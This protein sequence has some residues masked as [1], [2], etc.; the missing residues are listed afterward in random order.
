[1]SIN[2]ILLNSSIDIW[3]ALAGL[4]FFTLGMHFLED[5]LKQLT[6]RKFK[7]FLRKQSSRKI[8]AIGSA[9]VVTAI[10]QSSSVVNLM[11]LAFTGA[12]IIKMKQA[13]GL[14]LGS[15]LG[16]TMSTWF[17][18][19]VGFK[20]DIEQYV[21]PVIAIA[22]FCMML[23][24]KGSTGYNW[25]IFLF[26]LGFLFTGIDF[27]KNG[28]GDIASKFDLTGLNDYPSIVFLLLGIIITALI[29]SS[30]A[31]LAIVLSLLYVNA[32]TLHSGMAVAL[33]AEIGTTLKLLLV[34]TG[35]EPVKKRV[36][37]GN[38]LY[39]IIVALVIL[40]FLGPVTLLITDVLG[41]KDSLIALS[42]FQ[43]FTN[44]F[45]II[46]FFPLLNVFGGFLE[47]LF[48]NKKSLTEYIHKVP[49]TDVSLALVAVQK[50]T[51]FFLGHIIQFCANVM[52]LDGKLLQWQIIDNGYP[53]MS[54][55]EQYDYIKHYHGDIY[56][57]CIQLQ[58]AEISNEEAHH[59]DRLLAAIGNGL[60]AAKNIKD[61]IYDIDQLK[62]SGND[63][64]YAF[65]LQAKEKA[66]QFYLQLAEML[67]Q[68]K[69]TYFEETV[70]I[71]QAVQ[72]GFITALQQLYKVEYAEKLSETELSTIINFNR[73]LYT[74]FKS[75]TLVIKDCLF[76]N[77][78]VAA[79]DELPGFT[80]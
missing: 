48:V 13:L 22:G 60:Y 40:V 24:K 44:V 53:A 68:D 27:M 55:T 62:N 2:G 25:S 1:M 77:E 46:I 18:A 32:I 38:F 3:K 45:G 58:H 41:I 42:F 78:E 30:S 33:G 21:M 23:F 12:G 54:K 39:N 16:T 64:K 69:D 49:V 26:G 47:R 14:M 29:Q 37:L 75:I 56:A 8:T 79:F 20:L 10:L 66:N 36:A 7:L 70:R 57:Y 71:N 28:V 34:A 63:I 9:A 72:Q 31:T 51:T 50:E 74:S 15:N 43:T 35:G 52:E 6:G 4:A 80:H 67:Q 61:I 65:Y 17:V 76:T 59:L 19:T 73:E 11:I 5:G